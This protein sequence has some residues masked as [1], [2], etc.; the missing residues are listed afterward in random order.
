MRTEVCHWFSAGVQHTEKTMY[1]IC[2]S[3]TVSIYAACFSIVWTLIVSLVQITP[4]STLHFLG[5]LTTH[6]SSVKQIK[7]T[8]LQRRES[9]TNRFLESLDRL[10]FQTLR[11]G[12]VGVYICIFTFVLFRRI[13]QGCPNTR[14]IKLKLFWIFNSKIK[15]NRRHH[16]YFIFVSSFDL[17]YL[18]F[19][20]CLTLTISLWCEWWIISELPV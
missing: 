11:C 20:K 9:H 17:R 8:V 6:M 16:L 13:L 18:Y 5:P 10:Y 2:S 12:C 7:W 4:D 15:F 1:N 3:F 14:N 19:D